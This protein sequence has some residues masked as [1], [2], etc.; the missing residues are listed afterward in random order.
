NMPSLA[1]GGAH[2]GIEHVVDGSDRLDAAAFQ[3]DA[4]VA[5]AREAGTRRGREDEAP[6]GEGIRLVEASVEDEKGEPAALASVDTP[7]R[8]RIRYEITAPTTFRCSLVFLTQGAPAF[9]T[10][11]PAERS[12]GTPGV[13]D[14]ILEVPP[15]LLTEG[16]YVL[17]LSLLRSRGVK[18]RVVA[19][20]DLLSFALFDPMTGSTARGDY[21]EALVGLVRPR[22]AW[23]LERVPLGAPD[24]ART[25]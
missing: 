15:H 10:V 14:A 23:R 7:L 21:A 4:P 17:N 25:P 8:V 6:K 3:E 22:L 1:R 5:Q 24:D 19:A 11:E 20:P 12:Y 2:V 16:E 9:T 18:E 13:Y